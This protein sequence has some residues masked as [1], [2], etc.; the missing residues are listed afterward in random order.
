MTITNDLQS[1]SRMSVEE[2]LHLYLAP[3][4]DSGRPKKL[5]GFDS[6]L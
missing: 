1:G 2:L 4:Q 6:V 3:D 5:S